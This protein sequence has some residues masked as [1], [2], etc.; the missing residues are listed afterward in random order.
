MSEG[1]RVNIQ[2]S[3]QV[4]ELPSVLE[5]LLKQAETQMLQAIN[6]FLKHG[7]ARSIMVHEN[8]LNSA[9]KIDSLRLKLADLDY[10]L[11]DCSSMLKGLAQMRSAP[12]EPEPLENRMEE[13]QEAIDYT[14]Q[15]AEATQDGEEP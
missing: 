2:Y 10:R 4:E 9:E 1:Q 7:V 12:P 6:E 15:M 11:S 8:Y 14:K 5:Q 3:V 13:I